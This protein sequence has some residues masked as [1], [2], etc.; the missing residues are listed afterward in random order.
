[1]DE[2]N[3]GRIG[4]G[5][6]GLIGWVAILGLAAAVVWLLAERNARQFFL[7]PEDGLLVVKQGI[8]FVVGRRTFQTEDPVLAAVY[9][10]LVPPPGEALPPEGRFP[11][12]SELDQALFEVLAG[13]AKGDVGSGDESRLERGLGYLS[14]AEQLA[15]ISASQRDALS[16]LRAESA[17][18]E[19]QRLLARGAESLRQAAEKLRQASGSPSARGAEAQLLLQATE[20]AVEAALSALAA[21]RRPAAPPAA[22]PPAAPAGREGLEGPE[23][24]EAGPGDR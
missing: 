21:T 11:G 8:R 17:F 10:P 20:P 15:G 16:A 1:M 3:R 14:R 18:F 19:A 6:R 23:R 7:V 12:R 24:P 22:P 5:A 9:A 13:W 4:R 2:T